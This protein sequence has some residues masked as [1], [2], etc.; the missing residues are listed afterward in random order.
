MTAVVL[1]WIGVFKVHYT[2]PKRAYLISF[3]ILLDNWG[4]SLL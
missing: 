2:K 4:A 3:N 1:L